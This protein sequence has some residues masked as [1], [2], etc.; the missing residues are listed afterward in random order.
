MY[1]WKSYDDNSGTYGKRLS[2]S[3]VLD[4]GKFSGAA[5]GHQRRGIRRL[6]EDSASQTRVADD[7]PSAFAVGYGCATAAAGEMPFD[8]QKA[9]TYI[10]RER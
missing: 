10:T 8:R 3:T 7:V 1:E 2:R 9:A 5:G 6:E 4:H